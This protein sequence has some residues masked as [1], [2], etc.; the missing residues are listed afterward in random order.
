MNKEQLLAAGFSE[1]QVATILEHYKKALDGQFVPKHR[2]DEVNT[3]L[4]AVKEQL[5]DRDT[6]IEGLK[7]F[8]GDSQQLT[9]KIKELEEANKQKDT[10]YNAKLALERKRNLV[11]AALL[12]DPEGKPHDADMVMGLFNLEKVVVDE[13]V[14]KITS[15]YT[16]QSQSIRKEKA[17]LFEGKPSPQSP[18]GWKPKGAEP[19][20]G[21]GGTAPNT[22]EAYGKSLAAVKLGMMGV[23]PSDTTTQ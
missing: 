5:A 13:A 20:D 6:Q 12:E 15:G 16:E 2:F 9:A 23:A 8:E 18:Q 7:K 3:Q 10:E 22:S 1:A 11:R 17:F 14:G 4:K 21:D 19:K